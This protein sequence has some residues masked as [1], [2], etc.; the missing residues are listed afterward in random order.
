MIYGSHAHL[1]LMIIR[2]RLL[3]YLCKIRDSSVGITM[4]CGLDGRGYTPG[5]DKEFVSTP[6]RADRLW[7]PASLLS[8]GY[9]GRFPWC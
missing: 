4:G 5:R 7:C 9:R 3:L 8:N 1:I 6:Q 2:F